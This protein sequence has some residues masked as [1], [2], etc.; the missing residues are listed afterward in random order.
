MP[1]SRQFASELCQV[2]GPPGKD[3][4]GETAMPAHESI[5]HLRIPRGNGR[6]NASA[7]HGSRIPEDSP[8]SLVQMDRIFAQVPP[9]VILSGSGLGVREILAV[10]RHNVP[11]RFTAD[12]E[13]AARIS[14]CY[15]HMMENVREG[16]PVYGCNTGYGGQ[17]AQILARGQNSYGSGAHVPFPRASQPTTSPSDRSL[18]GTL[19][20]QPCWFG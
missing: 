12:S 11:V 2:G 3:L 13:V 6:A 20:A 5:D 14:A 9:E 10:A 18:T 19:L 1:P 17:A 4:L 16:V 15:E 7:N 8:A